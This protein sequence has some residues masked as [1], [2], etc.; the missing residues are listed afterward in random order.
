MGAKCCA[1]EVKETTVDEGDIYE[2]LQLQTMKIVEFEQR[3]KKYAYPGDRGKISPDA[4]MEA[5]KETGVK[6][7]QLKNPQSVVNKVIMSPFFCNLTLSHNEMS[8]EEI[9]ELEER[10]HQLRKNTS[11][12]LSHSRYES[13]ERVKQPVFVERTPIETQEG[14]NDSAIFRSENDRA[15]LISIDALML[16]GLL[17][18]KGTTYEKARA[19]YV[20]V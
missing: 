7:N 11:V 17:Q 6:F 19:F 4:L 5:F 13:N 2:R 8:L 12:N 9:K 15:G 16:A 3:V 20:I 14:N 18:C 10:A 1:T